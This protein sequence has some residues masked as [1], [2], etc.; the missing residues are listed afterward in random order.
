M[1]E[2]FVVKRGQLSLRTKRD[3]RLNGVIVV[4]VEDLDSCKFIR[5]ASPFDP[6]DMLWAALDAANTF[7]T[8][9]ERFCRNMLNVVESKRKDAE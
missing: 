8:G 9:R 7:S 1:A 3:L 5:S 4:E 6:D 2:I